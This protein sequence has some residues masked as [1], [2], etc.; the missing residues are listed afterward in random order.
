MFIKI[1]NK[2]SKFE[3]IIKNDC[4]ECLA[5]YAVPH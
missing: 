3:L 2:E 4:Y 1:G 5:T